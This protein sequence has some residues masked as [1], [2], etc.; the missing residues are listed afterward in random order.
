MIPGHC[1]RGLQGKS[2]MKNDNIEVSVLAQPSGRKMRTYF[3]EGKYFIESREN[4]EYAIEIE[5]K[6]YNRVEVV[7]SVD[8]LSVLSGESASK[9]DRG[10]V[11]NSK[12]K[13]T[14]KGYRK[15]SDTVGAFKFVRKDKSYVKAQENDVS[16]AGVIALVVYAEKVSYT[17][18]NYWYQQQVTP[19]Y[20]PEWISTVADIPAF[21]YDSYNMCK[22]DPSNTSATLS[23]SNGTKGTN[24]VSGSSGTFA[25]ANYTSTLRCLQEHDTP[26]NFSHGTTWGQKIDDKTVN[27]EFTRAN[28]IFS[29]SVFYN[30]WN[31]LKDAGIKLVKEK[32]ISLPN[33]FPADK[34]AK[35]PVG[36]Q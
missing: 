33:G 8:G 34:F 28:E 12:D 32:Q 21:T 23:Y 30:S 19:R 36:W 15:D 27:T 26:M 7:V 4:S 18:N 3:H 17:L 9:E 1:G 2:N 11:I 29:L 13:I 22:S 14:I 24:G 16:N 10:Y 25:S 5:N 31:N 35:P 6:T 20:Y